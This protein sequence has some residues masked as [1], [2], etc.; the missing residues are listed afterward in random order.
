M[1]PITPITFAWLIF[2]AGFL[3]GI[4][5][6]MVRDW[7]DQREIDNA[8]KHH[9]PH[10]LGEFNGH[11]QRETTLAQEITETADV[12]KHCGNPCV[13]EAANDWRRRCYFGESAGYQPIAA[14]ANTNP[15]PR[16]P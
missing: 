4:A 5:V 1:N 15:P 16:M 11:A 10:Y 3:F 7:L 9:G 12:L 14:S 6:C 8:I 2:T 13:Q